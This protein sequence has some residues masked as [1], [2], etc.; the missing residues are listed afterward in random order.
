MAD[1]LA[2]PTGARRFLTVELTGP[3]DVSRRPNHVQLY[4]FERKK[5][6]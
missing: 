5:P 6:C 2:D 3:I 1:V 4:G